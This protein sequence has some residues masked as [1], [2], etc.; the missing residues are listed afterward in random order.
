MSRNTL[1]V[2][3]IC[4]AT[5]LLFVGIINAQADLSDQARGYYANGYELHKKRKYRDAVIEF[6]RA[7]TA[8]PNYGEAYYLLGHCYHTLTDFDR[9]IKSFEKA[10]SLGFL[11]VKSEKALSLVYPKAAAFSYQRGKYRE[12]IRRYEQALEL[13]S[14]V[15]KVTLFYQIGLAYLK[16]NREDDAIQ[17]LVKATQ[18]NPNFMKAHKK[19]ADI[20][21]RKR[22]F[23]TATKSYL[24]TIEIDSTY[25]AAYGGLALTKFATEDIDGV[26]L[27]MK[28]AT[29]INPAYAD[30][31]LL[32][33]TA[34]T[35]MGRQHEA[36]APLRKAI[37]ID[38][39]N[40]E[41]HFR[42]GEALYGIGN[43][44]EARSSSEQ[45]LRKKKELVAA[46]SLLGDTHFKLGEFQ[47]AKT[48]YLKAKESS[49]F[50]DYATAQLE[51][52]E[53]LKKSP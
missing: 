13:A 30:G 7:V 32:L 1:S 29:R 53:R 46:Q 6:E 22:E 15:D 16:S 34:L 27:L 23:L 11:P 3:I 33:G 38:H 47:E 18:I 40:A 14:E 17:S 50:K 31:Y 26:I 37:D 10:V 35:Q 19:L 4:F 20:Y 49:R 12:A 43:Y 41:A 48:W 39:T 25:T 44:R 2:G 42:L 9:S 5:Q 45:A 51:E 24:K 28:K 21:H 52:I 36:I 8:S